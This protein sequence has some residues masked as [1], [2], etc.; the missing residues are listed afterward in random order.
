MLKSAKKILRSLGPGMIITAS[1]IGPGTVTTMTQGGAGFGYSLLWAV[2][3]SIIATIVLQEMIIRLSLVTREGLGEAI[4]D[5]FKN[6]LGKLILVWFTLIAVTI[7][8]A[9][10]I[11]GDLIGTSLGASYLLNLPEHWVA[12]VIGVIILLI[13]L[14]GNYRFLEKIM[15]LLMVIMGIIFITTMIVIKPDVIGIL[16]GI[17]VPTIPNGSILTV[18][19][20]IGTTVVPYNFFIHSTAVHE[21]FGHIKELKFARWDTVISISV[22]GIISA[23]ILIS[24]ATL[25]QGKEVTSVIQLAG[26]LEPV[27]GDAAPIAISVGLF[28]A[29]LSSAIASPT[30]AAATISSLLGWQGGMKSKKYKAVFT[31]I[32]IIGIITSALGFEPLQVLLI[33]QALNGIILPIVA[34]LIFIIINKKNLMGHFTNTIWLNIIGGIVVLVVSFL[35]IYSLMDAI[36][37]FMS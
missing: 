20:L 28:A 34:I 26:P 33:A 22:G 17:F 32:I 14:F 24:A 35:G 11:S 5:L 36:S 15:I 18:I 30:G 2:A 29:G 1:F 10:Y 21:R 7:G 25:I 27:L 13:G 6:K 9:A 19:A 8:C 3:F 37:T 16:K 31:I 4:Q 12:P 23:A